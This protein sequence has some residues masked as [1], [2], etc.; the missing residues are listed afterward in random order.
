MLRAGPALVLLALAAPAV[1][2]PR[3]ETPA[4]VD[5]PRAVGGVL[6]CSAAFRDAAAVTYA[7]RRDGRLV[8]RAALHLVRRA[9]VG[10][11]LVCEVTARDGIEVA[12]TTATAGVPP[13]CRVPAVVGMAADAA[14][15]AA[16][17]RGCRVATVLV[18]AP[19]SRP[20]RVVATAPRAGTIRPNGA[21]VTL[22]V[23]R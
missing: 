4:A 17:A 21:T 1:A 7:W 8:G 19:R 15:E 12:T 13:A 22:R 10:R 20:G 14:R 9:D 5:G 2:A 11:S 6:V 23:A 18:A 16:G 3:V